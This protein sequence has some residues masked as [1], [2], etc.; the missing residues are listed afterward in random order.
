MKGIVFK[1]KSLVVGP[2]VHHMNWAKKS[3]EDQIRIDNEIVK[4]S[5]L[6]G[7]DKTKGLVTKFSNESY[8][9]S[10]IVNTEYIIQKLKEAQDQ[11]FRSK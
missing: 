4:T 11:F 6:L 9:Q 10:E 3:I 8:S 5:K 2:M 1:I 7:V